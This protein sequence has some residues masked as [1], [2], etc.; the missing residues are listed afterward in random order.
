M[1]VS[2]KQRFGPLTVG[3]SLTAIGYVLGTLGAREIV[4]KVHSGASA[5]A[6]GNT[7]VYPSTDGVG[8]ANA[9]NAD[10][11][12]APAAIVGLN[13]AEAGGSWQVIRMA[14]NQPIPF[15]NLKLYTSNPGGAVTGVIF[16]I[17]LLFDGDGAIFP[18][19]KP[20]AGAVVLLP[21]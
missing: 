18:L 17:W 7:A 12:I 9:S 16:D 15:P 3:T 10:M 2:G 19:L 13:A 1:H 11:T 8:E 20:G 5:G 21:S 6:P 14:G 4:I